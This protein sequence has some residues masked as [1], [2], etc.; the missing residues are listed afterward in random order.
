MT[1]QEEASFAPSFNHSLKPKCT[2]ALIH[3]L[4]RV[5]GAIVRLHLESAHEGHHYVHIPQLNPVPQ[6]LHLHPY[7]RV[8]GSLELAISRQDIINVS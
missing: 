8:E 7:Q 3:L 2:A 4:N 6:R 1:P 5:G